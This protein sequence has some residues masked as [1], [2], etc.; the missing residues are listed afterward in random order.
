[1]LQRCS[2]FL[3]YTIAY[4]SEYCYGAIPICGGLWFAKL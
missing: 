3:D 4:Y 1:M 2:D